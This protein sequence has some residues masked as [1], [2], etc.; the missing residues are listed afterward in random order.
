MPNQKFKDFYLDLDLDKIITYFR[1]LF[2]ALDF[3]HWKGIIHCDIKPENFI[4]NIREKSYKLIDFENSAELPNSSMENHIIG[5][6]GYIAPEVLILPSCNTVYRDMWS[7]GIILLSILSGCYPFFN[8]NFLK[9]QKLSS[10]KR[11]TNM[12][13]DSLIQMIVLF[14]I[15]DISNLAKKIGFTI[16]IDEPD[17]YAKQNLKDLC[18]ILR[19]SANSIKTLHDNIF[20]D[21]SAIY[22]IMSE[23]LNI[24]YSK[25]PSAY[26]VLKHLT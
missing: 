6:Y 2:S 7:A 1:N 25:R 11:C 5:T 21:D 13:G 19:H 24:D 22:N 14:G 16:N 17:K 18:K 15:E 3:I 8:I 12:I 23:L 26:D 4:C 10:N 9:Y 20:V